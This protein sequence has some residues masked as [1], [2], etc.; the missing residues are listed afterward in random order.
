MGFFTKYG[1]GGVDISPIGDCMKTQV[2]AMA[3]ELGIE[4]EIID[5][6]P[7]DGLW[8]DGR[9]DESQLG[10]TYP[11][12]ELAM[13]MDTGVWLEEPNKEQAQNLRRYREIR[14]RNMHKMMPI[15]VC[16]LS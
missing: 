8:A 6:P 5:A 2:W 4:K 13:G 3:A 15:P 11:E 14:A 16:S 12:L 7:T 9:T 10:M 1:D